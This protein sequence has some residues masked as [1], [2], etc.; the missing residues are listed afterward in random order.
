MVIL[1]GMFLIQPPPIPTMSF[2]RDYVN[3]LLA[4]YV[5]SH[6]KAGVTAVHV[7]FDNPGSLKEIEPRR[8]DNTTKDLSAHQC[9]HFSSEQTI[10]QVHGRQY[11]STMQENPDTLPS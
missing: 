2:M 10:F 7:V 1:E 8:W 5:R 3:L 11:L 6:L 9:I 4:K